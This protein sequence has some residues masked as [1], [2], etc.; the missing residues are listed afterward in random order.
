MRSEIKKTLIYKELDDEQRLKW[1]DFTE[2]KTVALIDNIY[3]SVFLDGDF[4]ETTTAAIDNLISSLAAMKKEVL[5]NKIDIEVAE[6]LFV[7]PFGAEQYNLGIGMKDM[8]DIFFRPY[9]PNNDTN[10]IIVQIRSLGL[11]LHG[12]KKMLDTSFKYLQTFLDYF[13]V[14]ISKVQENRIDFAHH[15]NL[16]QSPEKLFINT[17]LNDHCK[18]SAKSKFTFDKKERGQWIPSY[19]AFGVRGK[20]VYSRIY[21]KTREVVEQG[22]KGVAFKLWFDNGLIS[23]YDKYVL[24]KCYED[25]SYTKK[26]LHMIDFYIKKGKDDSIKMELLRLR[27]TYESDLSVLEKK[28]LKLGVLPR[29]TKILNIEFETKRDF[30]RS[31]EDTFLEFKHTPEVGSLGRMYKILDNLG[32]FQDYLTHYTLRFVN[33]DGSYIDFWRRIR[34]SKFISLTKF[35]DLKD[36][37]S[38]NRNVDTTLLKTR[39][40]KSLASYI[41][42]TNLD[43]SKDTSIEEDLVDMIDLINDNDIHRQREK[44]KSA[45]EKKLKEIQNLL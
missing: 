26:A 13:G 45:K 3:Y 25:R 38:Y 9:L 42:I 28:V 27:N 34:T 19:V 7:L 37:R 36:L 5:E 29:V 11:W 24:E 17:Y 30:F 18:T 33:E 44:Y 39:V 35:T 12:H 32:I 21:D 4:K 14:S 16:I 8:F 22:Y 43:N 1:F 31:C 40:I 23:R 20:A 15:T 10:R 41:A 2:K 6:G